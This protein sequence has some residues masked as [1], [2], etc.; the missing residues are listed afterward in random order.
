MGVKPATCRFIHRCHAVGLKRFI[1]HQ[2]HAVQQV[3]FRS[4]PTIMSRNLG[5]KAGRFI[6]GAVEAHKSW[7]MLSRHVESA[8]KHKSSWR[9]PC[10][11]GRSR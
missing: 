10:G 2:V 7:Q 11:T 9:A 8:Q 5:M 3:L 4:S 6:P 1:P